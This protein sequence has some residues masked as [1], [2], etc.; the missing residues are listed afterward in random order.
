MNKFY[1]FL[2]VLIALS[3]S[4]IIAIQPVKASGDF[5]VSKTPMPNGYAF[6]AVTVNGEIYVICSNYTYLYD[7]SAD[8]WVSKTPM[9]TPING[10]ATATYQN[11]IYVF[12]GI[13]GTDPNTGYPVPTEISQEYNP[14]TDTWE[15]KASMPTPRGGL[16]A[17][18]VNG[19]IYLISGGLKTNSDG[20]IVPN[21]SNANEA[22]DPLTNS[23]ATMATIPTPAEY[24]ASAVVDNKIYVI[25]GMESIQPGG[26]LTQ[27]YDP[28]TNTWSTGQ[29]VPIGFDGAKAGATTGVWAPK[30]IY[31][32]GWNKTQVYDPQ[33]NSWTSGMPPKSGGVVAVVNDTLYVMQGH[34]TAND[35][36]TGKQTYN[37]TNEQ[38]FP[39][40]YQGPMPSP[41]AASNS[42]TPNPTST[43]SPPLSS[44]STPTPSLTHAPTASSSPLIS[45]QPTSSP[46]PQFTIPQTELVY[47][48]AGAAVAI[49]AI[50]A[51]AVVVKKTVNNWFTRR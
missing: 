7:P 25:G 40:G 47:A 39:L 18:V 32:I 51:V 20:P 37:G 4:F 35:F 11:K 8:I 28:E 3:V 45:Q 38:Y 2:F 12:G 29:P 27:I 49:V 24:Y 9:P 31:V 30:R 23:W 16:Q 1:A 43:I 19:K 5:W 44:V 10:F 14:A 13:N 46:E 34:Y 6:G 33:A 36:F 17:N 41:S 26:D 42:P 22:Y 50:A 21:I 15:T 48:V